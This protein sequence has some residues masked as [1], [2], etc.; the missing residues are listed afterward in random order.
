MNRFAFALYFPFIAVLLFAGCATSTY[1]M[2]APEPSPEQKIRQTLELWEGTHISQAIQKWG[3]PHE[4]TGEE[5]NPKIYT[6]QTLSSDN[7]VYEFIFH[8]H[9]NGVIH[10]TDTRRY[11][12]RIHESD[13]KEK[14]ISEVIQEW[15]TPHGVIDD[16]TG[17]K[18]YIWQMPVLELLPREYR[19]IGSRLQTNGFHSITGTSVPTSDA[20]EL[21]L[22]TRPDGVIYKTLTKKELNA[23]AG[24]RSLRVSQEKQGFTK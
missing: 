23:S 4:I 13:W 22:Y 16:G 18:I 1:F 21:M 10:I 14:H 8:T 11:Q 5:V 24:S 9:S 19:R 2:N 12:N 17:S 7:A 3:S 15:G 6:W 20:Y